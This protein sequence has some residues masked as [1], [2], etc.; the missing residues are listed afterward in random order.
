M[1]TASTELAEIRE[2]MRRGA[3][4]YVLKD[5]LGPEMLLPIVEGIREKLQLKGEIRRLREHIEKDFGPGALVGS[6]AAMERVRRLVSRLG[7]RRRACA[8]SRRDW[9]RQ[10]DGGACHPSRRQAQ[11]RGRSSRSTAQPSQVA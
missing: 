9:E 5:E 6:S 3:T 11:Q 7:G 2:A 10:G 4:D 1:I 8:H